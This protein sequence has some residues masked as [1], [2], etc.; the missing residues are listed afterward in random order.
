MIDAFPTPG[1]ESRPSYWYSLPHGYIQLDLH[2]ELDHVEAL[3]TWVLSLP[4]KAR[5][6]AERVLQFYAGFVT[7]LNSQQV[8]GCAIGLH[9]DGDD[10]ILFSV[11]TVSSIAV[12]GVDPRLALASTVKTACERPEEDLQSVELPCGPGVLTELNRRTTA[13]GRPPTGSEGALEG[14]VWQGTL[15]VAGTGSSDIIMMQLVTAAAH[16]S[17]DYRNVLLGAASTLTFTDPSL[18]AAEDTGRSSGT[19][20]ARSPFG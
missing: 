17:D 9:P 4:E 7:L 14:T 16:L 10:G 15:T 11:L 6:K 1:G 12:P 3:A 8:Q 13:P 2:P 20:T 18:P 5:E 19:D